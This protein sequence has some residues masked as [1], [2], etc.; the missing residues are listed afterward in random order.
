MKK[1]FILSYKGAKFLEQQN[2]INS[3]KNTES[4]IVDNGQQDWNLLKNHVIHTTKTNTGCA[5]GWGICM[6]I[7]FKH[8]N[9]EKI[10][11]A[12]DDVFYTDTIID[13][14]F[15]NCTDNT[16]CGAF[17]RSF[18]F[19][20]FCISKK[21]YEKIGKP[22]EN[23]MWTSCEDDDLKWRCHLANINVIS[24]NKNADANL[25]MSSQHLTKEQRN[26]NIEYINDKWGIPRNFI[27]PFNGEKE[28]LPSENLKTTYQHVYQIGGWPS[29]FE[30]DRFL[31]LK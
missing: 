21:V 16:I 19:S 1:M 5:S 22:D 24:L 31:Q 30:Y 8:F 12:N 25:C 20:L 7:G 13:E 27:L 11:I 6:D 4:Y 23:F 29:D 17:D 9:C 10:V 28:L 2:Q 26:A 3:V 18:E 14:L 15:L